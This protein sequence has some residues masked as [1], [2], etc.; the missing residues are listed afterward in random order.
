MLTTNAL[1][2]FFTERLSAAAEEIFG[3]VEK[4]ITEYQ[5]EV[6]RS[7]NE[8]DRLQRLLEHALKQNATLHKE[9]R[10][11]TVFGEEAGS[12]QR[13]VQEWSPSRSQDV[14]EPP[15]WVKIEPEE[16]EPGCAGELIQ[17][18]ES[19]LDSMLSPPHVKSDHDD[20]VLR[21]LSEQQHLNPAQENK[22]L[23]VDH[24]ALQP[25][26]ASGEF[27]T[28]ILDS[29]RLGQSPNIARESGEFPS[30]SN[31]KSVCNVRRLTF[32]HLGVKSYT[33]YT[34]RKV[35]PNKLKLQ[36]HMR[37]HMCEKPYRWHLNQRTHNA[38]EN[39]CKCH[40][41]GEE[42]GCSETL[43]AH[44]NTHSAAAYRNQTQSR[45]NPETES[46]NRPDT[47]FHAET[48]HCHACS[49]VFKH[50]ANLQTHMRTHTG[51]KPYDCYLC[52]KGFTQMGNLNIHMRIHT[53]DR[54]FECHLCGHKCVHSGNLKKHMRTHTKEKPYKCHD[55]GKE[56]GYS[57][58]LKDH[59][60]TH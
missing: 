17:G 33:C 36:I 6:S 49:K 56:F 41:C 46:L 20:E 58:T 26:S 18:L 51:E 47:N 19:S 4:T 48:Y 8:V 22:T 59:M 16:C 28:V 25:A 38:S 43:K 11:F 50:K 7:K 37:T 9:D 23:E 24:R 60:K 39:L 53:G 32:T 35:F 29:P 3:V 52:G 1:R 13:T 34:C 5:E 15:E 55:C 27:S 30:Y 2:V 10:Q 57:N 54:P 12:E 40:E 44:M 45:E 21:L 31:S 14:L 42:F